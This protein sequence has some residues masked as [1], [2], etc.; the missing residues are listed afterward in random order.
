MK[1]EKCKCPKEELTAPFYLLTYGDMMTLLLT[2]FVLLF[3]MSTMQTIK[4]QAKI[5][6]LQGAMGISQLYQHAPMEIH[7]PAPS[8]KQSSRVV[9]RAILRPTKSSPLA[10]SA[11]IDSYDPA[12]QDQEEQVQAI[13]NLGLRNQ[14][15]VEQHEDEVIIT[16]PTYGIFNKGEWRIDP[17]SPEVRRLGK[18]YRQLAEQLSHLTRYDIRFTGHTDNLPLEQK[19]E[20]GSPQSNRELGFLRAAGLFDFFFANYLTDRTRISF[21]SQGDN[22]PI[23]PN[24][25][26]DSELRKNRRVQISLKKK[27]SR[28]MI[29]D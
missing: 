6:V 8:L 24:A 14:F 25:K 29:R 3:S 26:L 13:K 17:N 2:F 20:P 7:L 28:R 9:A 27:P 23:I 5:G 11:E 18:V 15:H 12:R 1:K 19:P 21:A 22:V 4:F 16:L 10:E